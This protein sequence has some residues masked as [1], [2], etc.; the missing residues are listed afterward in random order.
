MMSPREVAFVSSYPALL[1]LRTGDR[2]WL[3]ESTQLGTSTTAWLAVIHA[4]AN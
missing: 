3:I 4:A 2:P 1:A